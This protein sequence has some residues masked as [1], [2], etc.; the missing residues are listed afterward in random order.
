LSKFW[1]NLIGLGRIA[2]ASPSKFLGKFAQFGQNLSKLVQNLGKL[3]EIW[4]N[5]DN[6]GQI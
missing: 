2:A 6:L 4:A 1:V 5:L 3:G